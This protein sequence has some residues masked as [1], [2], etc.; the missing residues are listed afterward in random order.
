[1]SNDRS[2]FTLLLFTESLHTQLATHLKLGIKK[3]KITARRQPPPEK[4]RAAASR[5]YDGAPAG[6][7]SRQPER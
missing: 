4:L 2:T 5:I 1:V 3:K 6:I 7:A